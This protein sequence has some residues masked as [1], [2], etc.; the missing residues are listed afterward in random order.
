MRHLKLMLALVCLLLA[1]PLKADM[2]VQLALWENLQLVDSSESITGIRLNVY[3][4]NQN[5]NGLDLGFLHELRGSGTGMQYGL[6]SLTLHDFTGIQYSLI[7][8]NVGAEMTGLQFSNIVNQARDM[9]GIQFGMVNLTESVEGLQ[10]G[11]YN[12]TSKLRGAQIGLINHV[13][14][15]PW[16]ILPLFRFGN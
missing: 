11:L 3:G 16:P 6:V 12:Q 15:H 13:S 9:Q 14:G 8:T 4:V 1:A 5:L 2:P 7:Y 10:I